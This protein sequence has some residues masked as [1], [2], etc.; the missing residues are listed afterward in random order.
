MKFKLQILQWCILTGDPFP[1]HK[2]KKN[3]ITFV[4][5]MLMHFLFLGHVKF[6]LPAA[7]TLP[8]D[9]PLKMHFPK[10]SKKCGCGGILSSSTLCPWPGKPVEGCVVHDFP[11]TREPLE[12]RAFSSLSR[13][14]T[15]T[16]GA[17]GLW[18]WLGP[19]TLVWK[20]FLSASCRLDCPSCRAVGMA[21]RGSCRSL[22]SG[23]PRF[24]VSHRTLD[25]R[26]RR[27]FSSSLKH[28]FILLLP[29]A[30]RTSL[31]IK[32]EGIS[33]P[34]SIKTPGGFRRG[35][36]GAECFPVSHHC[37]Q[38]WLSEGS[39]FAPS[40]EEA[41]G[42]C[43]LHKPSGMPLEP[44]GPRD[45]SHPAG[46]PEGNEEKEGLAKRVWGK[47]CQNGVH[48]TAGL[49]KG[50]GAELSSWMYFP[51]KGR[52]QNYQKSIFYFKAFC[53]GG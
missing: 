36:E 14:W 44:Q 53:F 38:L 42:C 31:G 34:C 11:W 9:Q 6:L 2:L 50:A 52:K 47:L 39:S 51:P 37:V 15:F 20:M 33:V 29:V 24:F 35:E 40:V 25:W 3:P 17:R 13:L 27:Q 4:I 1:N 16:Q 23:C 46:D 5:K 8:T 28:W 32:G 45:V 30:L 49:V 18:G 21:R 10:H 48:F 22:G 26:F 12:G 19:C 43:E 41:G 7:F